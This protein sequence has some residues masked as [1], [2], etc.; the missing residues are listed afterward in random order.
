MAEPVAR[1]WFRPGKDKL[2]AE[3][4]RRRD[5]KFRFKIIR[6]RDSIAGTATVAIPE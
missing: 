5:E 1:D 2:T 3:L 6:I 4:V